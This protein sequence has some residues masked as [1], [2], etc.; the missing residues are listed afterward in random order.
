MQEEDTVHALR[1]AATAA[2]FR[3][4]KERQGEEPRQASQQRIRHSETAH[5]P[6]R[7]GGVRSA[8]T[9]DG[10]R[11]VEETEQSRNAQTCRRVHQESETDDRGSRE[12]HVGEL[13]REFF[14]RQ[15]ILH[16]QPRSVPVVPHL[17]THTD[18]F[19]GF[20]F[21]D[22]FAQLRGVLLRR[23]Q[24]HEHSLPPGKLRKLRTQESGRRGTP[25][26]DIL[27]ATGR[28]RGRHRNHPPTSSSSEII[29]QLRNSTP[30]LY[31]FATLYIVA[32][33]SPVHV[34]FLHRQVPMQV[35]A[36]KKSPPRFFPVG[37]MYFLISAS[38]RTPRQCRPCIA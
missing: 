27:L 25:R 26:R 28:I 30:V 23:L 12:R 1:R 2:G 19:R 10:T 35:V 14:A 3:G 29:N 11:S 34:F 33:K 32:L 8:R 9:F 18:V 20:G 22:A 16:Q 37:E 6:E 17:V 7:G 21:A 31:F 13:Q 4:E 36:K 5:S 15:Q 38:F 24:L